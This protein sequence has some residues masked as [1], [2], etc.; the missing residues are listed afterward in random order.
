[1]IN[2]NRSSAFRR[3]VMLTHMRLFRAVGGV[4]AYM[5]QAIA[6]DPWPHRS[7]TSR[8][9]TLTFSDTLDATPE[10]AFPLFCPVREY[11]WIEDWDCTV[12]HSRSG[13]AEKGCVFT[14]QLALG[15]TWVCSRHEPDRSIEFVINAGRHLVITFGAT[16]EAGEDGTEIC[17]TR[18]LISLDSVGN[19]FLERYRERT[20]RREMELLSRRLKHYLATGTCLRT[21]EA[22]VNRTW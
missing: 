22:L 18:T 4:A 1:M 16:L 6:G 15:E 2:S 13:F 19:R 21:G 7:F 9:K 11:D 14:T 12:V 17:W 10:E 3:H 20:Y 8:H 5:Q